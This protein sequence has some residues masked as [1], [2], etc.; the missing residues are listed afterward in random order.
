MQADWLV[1]RSSEAVE[2]ARRKGYAGPATVLPNAFDDALFRPLD[3]ETCRQELGWEGFVVGYVGRMVQSKGIDDLLVALRDLPPIVNVVLVGDGPDREALTKRAA[4]LGVSDRVRWTGAVPLAGLPRMM[5]AMD[6]L[7]LPSRTT[8]AWKEQFGRV[9]IEAEA[10]GTPAIGS[11]SGAIAEVID[12]PSR[13]FRER[14][15]DSLA[16]VV[17]RMIPPA[18]WSAEDRERIAGRAADQFTWQRVADRYVDVYRQMLA[19]DP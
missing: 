13:I 5:N 14:D 9:L 2:V 19:C 7:I 3:R 16:A 6:T 1:G 18:K 10:C 4:D 12:D 17:R 8:P 11:D 15:P